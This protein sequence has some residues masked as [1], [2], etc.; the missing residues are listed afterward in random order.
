LTLKKT[1]KELLESL[2]YGFNLGKDCL[3]GESPIDP[4]EI[5]FPQ[6]HLLEGELPFN[7]KS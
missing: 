5:S 1:V 6:K 4:I 7:L 2:Y 3:R